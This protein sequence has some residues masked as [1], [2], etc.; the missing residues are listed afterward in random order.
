MEATEV[1]TVWDAFPDEPTTLTRDSTTNIYS[2]VT[3]KLRK[4][5]GQ[6]LENFVTNFMQSI[7]PNVADVAE[8]VILMNEKKTAT[9]K[10]L[11]PGRNF[12]FGD[13]FELK[14][15]PKYLNQVV[16]VH[17][18]RG[19]SQC[20][21]YIRKLEMFLQD[22]TLNTMGPTFQWQKFLTLRQLSSNSS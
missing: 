9:K 16:Q 8:D 14:Y 17:N 2:S 18:V 5:R 1:P 12:V 22:V 7:E 10:P 19:P 20:L 3:Q 15:H 13:L 11:P 6:N 21:I 4:E